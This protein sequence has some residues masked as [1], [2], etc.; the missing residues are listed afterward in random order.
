[1]K[2][3]NLIL[4]SSLSLFYSCEDVNSPSSIIP[5]NATNIKIAS[6]SVNSLEISWRNNNESLDKILIRRSVDD[7]D[8][9]TIATLGGADST[10]TDNNLSKSF[11]Y[12]YSVIPISASGDEPYNKTSFKVSYN[13]SQLSGKL[14]SH[15]KQ[16]TDLTFSE[17]GKYLASGSWDGSVKIWD[18]A[19]KNLKST[20]R[21]PYPD[22]IEDI[23]FTYDE[24]YIAGASDGELYF[25]DIQSASHYKTYNWGDVSALD[26]SPISPIFAA[27]KSYI[28][29]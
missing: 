13:I 16:V 9:E 7:E 27:D 18:I 25:W 22:E 15:T 14:S 20:L 5:T 10:F 21:E 28:K 24:K 4:I 6:L 23:S 19:N 26:C 12:Y 8:F 17:D 2:F 3:R 11:S 29:S 1:M